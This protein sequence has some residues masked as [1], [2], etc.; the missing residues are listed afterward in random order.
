MNG[1]RTHHT[2]HLGA[3]KETAVKI[4]LCYPA[5]IPGQKPTYGLQP[6]GVLYIAALL[7][8][9]RDAPVFPTAD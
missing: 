5:L 8:R 3:R 9:E 2:E 7:K 6:L 4:T 1:V